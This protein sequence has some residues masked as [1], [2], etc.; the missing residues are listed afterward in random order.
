MGSNWLKCAILPL[1]AATAMSL[2]GQTAAGEIRGVVLE[3]GTAQPIAGAEVLVFLE[4]SGTA[5]EG[6]GKATTDAAGAFDIPMPQPG[7]YRVEA[8]KPGWD[9]PSLGPRAT[10]EVELEARYPVGEVKLFLGHFGA[11]TG[12]IVDGA[13]NPIP[14]LRLRAVRET[15]RGVRF[16][17]GG[18]DTKTDAEG[19]F[20][21]SGLASGNYVAEVLP[22]AGVQERVLS[23]F[24]EE[25]AAKVDPD[26]EPAYWPGGH[27]ADAA[28]PV[29][30]A[31]GAT[32]DMGKLPARQIPYYRV[33]VR[34]P[35]AQCDVGDTM[36]VYETT[37]GS[38]AGNF[39]QR[40]GEAPCGKDIL[41][42]GHSPGDFR[43]LLRVA[44]EDGSSAS[45]PFLIED[46]NITVTA[47]ILAD[48]TVEGA[49]IT[50]EGAGAI[51]FTQLSVMLNAADGV[52]GDLTQPWPVDSD[53]KFR[54]P[55]VRPVGQ[56]VLVRGLDAAHYV[57]EILYNG[58][59]LSGSTVPLDQGAIAPSLR[60]VLDDKPASIAGRV[61]GPGDP[62]SRP[63]VLAVKW[64]LDWTAPGG[65]GKAQADASG[66]FLITGLS[67]GEYRLIAL[68][69]LPQDLM[70]VSQATI[71]R[72][73]A[74]GE[75][76]ELSAGATVN[77]TLEIAVLPVQ[78]AR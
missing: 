54:I 73:L 30:V 51:D 19:R 28:L 25:D 27:G 55:Y 41:V 26:Y 10:G 45:V 13:G 72:I 58:S 2:H 11:L 17:P 14:N 56:A 21:A 29:A 8:R 61:M 40:I 12:V 66:A 9:A 32:V 42:T 5:R 62:T 20:T 78:Q 22:Q 18:V 76:C 60:I 33:H 37:K 1:L 36:A 50:A 7:R 52:L 63:V 38:S 59:A 43:L 65:L 44:G 69:S 6:S 3:S 31:G 77:I 75:K 16:P 57:K 53:G 74:G 64:P 49:F 23:E 4:P 67:P 34:I 24:T 39:N 46:Q 48:L 35:V 71:E 68:P 47:L 70:A 15:N